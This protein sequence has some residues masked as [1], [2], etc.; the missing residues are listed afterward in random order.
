M[1]SSCRS[2]RNSVF[3]FLPDRYANIT[4][5]SGLGFGISDKKNNFAEDGIDETSGLFRLNSDCSTEQKTRGIPFRTVP[6][7]RKMLG[8][9]YR[10]KKKG[11]TLSE[12]RSETFRG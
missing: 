6:W 2:R 12:F 7:K 10:E 3:L 8:I 1:N 11:K 4:A 5:L 9:P